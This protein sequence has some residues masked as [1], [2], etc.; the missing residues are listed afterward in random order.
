MFKDTHVKSYKDL[1]VL[2]CEKKNGWA[3]VGQVTYFWDSPHCDTGMGPSELP[4]HVGLRESNE[5][6]RKAIVK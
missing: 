1:D 4:L 6:D 5:K 2:F 3:I